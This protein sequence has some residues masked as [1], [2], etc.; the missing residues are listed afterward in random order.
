MFTASL[1]PS[2]IAST[3]QALQ[4]LREE[5][6]L[7]RAADS[8]AQRLYDGLNALGFQTGPEASPIVAVAMPDRDGAIAFW[9]AL[10]VGGALPES[11]PAAG[12][13]QQHPAAALQRQRRPHARADRHR[14]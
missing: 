2:I 11:G 4:R 14:H 8:N 5:P 9:N 10:L 6:A 12:H 13:A 3:L 7:R 1:P